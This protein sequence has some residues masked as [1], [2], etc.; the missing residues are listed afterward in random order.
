MNGTRDVRYKSVSSKVGHAIH[1]TNHNNILVDSRPLSSRPCSSTSSRGIM[2]CLLYFF[3]LITM[4][5]YTRMS[6]K[7]KNWRAFDRLRHILVSTPSPTSTRPGTVSCWKT[8][9]A[10]V[11]QASIL[12]VFQ[13]LSYLARTAETTLHHSYATGIGLTVD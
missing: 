3:L 13:L 5:P 10:S 1:N 2:C 12:F 4:L 8:Q 9:T 7:R 11:G 6:L